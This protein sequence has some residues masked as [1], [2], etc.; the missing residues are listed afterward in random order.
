MADGFIIRRGG[1]SRFF[2]TTLELD[3]ET[4]AFEVNIGFKPR[5]V[6]LFQTYKNENS[7]EI[8]I[9]ELAVFFD[10]ATAYGS[11]LYEPA[12][13]KQHRLLSDMTGLDIAQTSSGFVV[14]KTSAD[15]LCLHG[16]YKVYATA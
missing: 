8:S 7:G 5:S 1:A 16:T 14:A 6:L 10:G 9:E 2:E 11:I 4:D 3:T 15:S 12:S 13:A